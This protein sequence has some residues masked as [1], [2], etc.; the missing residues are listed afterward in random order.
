MRDVLY[1]QTDKNMKVVKEEVLLG[2]IA[3][4][5]CSNAKVLARN[6]IRRVTSLPKGKYGRYVLSATDL[7]R[8]NR[9]IG[10]KCIHHTSGEPTFVLTYENPNSKN[11]AVSWLK[12][13]LVVWL[14]FWNRIFDYDV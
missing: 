11:Q 2:E 10:G 6:Q 13:L 5:S 12:V 9:E 14:P 4:L 8:G 7:I 3:K 1:I